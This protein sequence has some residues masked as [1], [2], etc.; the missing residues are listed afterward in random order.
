MRHFFALT[1]IGVS[2]VGYAHHHAGASVCLDAPFERS[3]TCSM[4]QVGTRPR[5]VP[6]TLLYSEFLVKYGMYPNYLHYWIDRPLFWNRETRPAAFEYETEG[7]IAITA[8][9]LEK[10][11]L[12][13]LN[14]FVQPNKTRFFAD[15]SRWF[16]NAGATGLNV[17]PTVSY[18]EAVDR[19]GPN[20]KAFADALRIM[21]SNPHA[22][23]I[24]GKLLV[25]TYNY[26]LFNA[27]QHRQLMCDLKTE[28]GNDEFIICG[29]IP[30][31]L[32]HGLHRNFHAH[33]KL[34]EAEVESL[35]RAIRDVL[36][37][38]GG[39]QVAATELV[40]NANGQYCSY[41]DTT[42]FDAYTGPILDRLL[43]LPEYRTKVLGFYVH[44][45]Y[46]NHFSGHDHSE[47]GT[48]TLRHCLDRSVW[49]NP[50][51]LV[52]FEW[53]ELNENTMFQPTVWGGQIAGRILNY[54]SRFMKGLKSAPFA[55][56]DTSIP[57]VVLTY[58]AVAKLGEFIHFEMLSI[59]DGVW[60]KPMAVQ[61]EL[62]DQHGR[63]VAD[64]PPEK[65]DSTKLGSIDYRLSTTGLSGDAVLTPTL[66]VEGRTYD[67]FAPIRLD[68]TV[69]IN[70]KTVRQSLREKLM[71]TKVAA[72]V[73]SKDKGAFNFRIQAD[74][75]ETLSSVE[76]VENEN[77]VRALGAE[78]EYDFDSNVILRLAFTTPR[79]GAV[80]DGEATIRV[81]GARGCR[82]S[83]LWRANVNH[84]RYTLFED[85]SG[86]KVSNSFYAQEV[87]WFIQIPKEAVSA[88]R[89]HVSMK[90]A[91]FV[92][93]EFAVADLV[94]RGAESRQL[95]PET[96]FRVDV[97]QM[98][99]LPEL[100][101]PLKRKAV[102]WS[103]R[104][105][106]KTHR[107]VFHFRAIAES[108]RIWR[109]H[110]FVPAPATG[111]PIEISVWDDKAEKPAVART[112][113]DLLPV[114]EYRMDPAAGATLRNGWDPVFDA[115]LGSGFIYNEAYNEID[116]GR[117]AP[118]RRAP[119]WV[120]DG[121]DWCLKFDGV[122][123]YVN[124]PRE[125]L[126]NAAFTLSM[127]VK[128]ELDERSAMVLFRHA[129][130][131]RGSIALYLVN[132]ELVARWG[133]RDLSREP[134]FK[135]GLKVKDG[136]W[137]SISVSYDF[138]RFVFAVNG[139]RHE[140]PWVGRAWA[141]KPAIFGGHDK[142]ELAPSNVKLRY[143]RGLLR[144]LEI[145]HGS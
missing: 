88:A 144:K 78:K 80:K 63:R 127:D 125:A 60:K 92:P 66:I 59:P 141:F 77:E 34:T 97:R 108:G 46:I 103:G 137:N 64:F 73:L 38:A 114:L 134:T 61:L 100:P 133:D 130:W 29:D 90:G 84:G 55:G 113:S 104:V 13:G 132:G 3:E 12:D 102:D 20:V 117:I 118:G 2:V 54:Y 17:L 58:R 23:R 140:V 70:Y 109:S 36:D 57:P 33:G 123:D 83:P 76:L 119:E 50:D 9:Q 31:S 115:F 22:T 49:L 95:C 72:S 136:A 48:Y 94:A 39:I 107:P 24:G 81:T 51:Y 67:G 101:F 18:G 47:E 68:P 45:G 82:F 110:S 93:A 138:T 62:H 129:N 8:R 116:A 27:E 99:D 142:T 105:A 86:V 25:S 35:E 135:T 5:L 122:N 28:L 112:P 126:P 14:V 106:T 79:S 42:F 121:E 52:F 75:P 87:V 44:Q 91:D 89:L 43:R 74:F 19:S 128:P 21:Q 56:D 11:G 41:Y 65:M 26:R 6:E 69:C 139:Q 71:P 145:R 10:A 15:F 30:F 16:A 1:L 124:F 98:L 4:P 96:S 40:R 53:N 131:I 7:S 37:V 85:G 120:K 143:F 32:L 111:S